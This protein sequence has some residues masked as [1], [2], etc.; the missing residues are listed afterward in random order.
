MFD[1]LTFTLNRL[2]DARAAITVRG[3]ASAGFRAALLV[4]Y[5]FAIVMVGALIRG[6]L[7]G[8]TASLSTLLDWIA[9]SSTYLW[10]LALLFAAVLAIVIHGGNQS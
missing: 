8:E 2:K 6:L 5:S 4:G 9:L 3:V 10:P 7:D 1:R